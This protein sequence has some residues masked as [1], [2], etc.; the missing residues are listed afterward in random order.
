[1]INALQ[2]VI[3]FDESNHLIEGAPDNQIDPRLMQI[4]GEQQQ[5]QQQQQQQAGGTGNPLSPDSN[6]NDVVLRTRPNLPT[7]IGNGS[8]PGRGPTAAQSRAIEDIPSGQTEQ[9]RLDAR[10]R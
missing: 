8:E 3:D 10:N 5:Q 2:T 9:Q 1:M 7:N 6:N 4:F